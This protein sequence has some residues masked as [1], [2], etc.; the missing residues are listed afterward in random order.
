M[1]N[2]ERNY[3]VLL[4]VVK[5]VIPLD[6]VAT[7]CMSGVKI[8]RDL[9]NAGHPEDTVSLK[10]EVPNHVFIL[11]LENYQNRGGLTN[12]DFAHWLDEHGLSEPNTK[13]LFDVR[14]D[15]SHNVVYTFIGKVESK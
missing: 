12:V 10:I 3:L 1:E 11:K 5:G 2:L 7:S 14:V 8:W 15:C 9:V 6:H 13:L 4:N